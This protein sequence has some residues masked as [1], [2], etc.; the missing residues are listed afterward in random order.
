[1]HWNSLLTKKSLR[2]QLLF[3]VWFVSSLATFV[4]T[5]IQL[6]KDYNQEQDLALS[7]IE[8]IKAN[9]IPSIIKSLWD[10]NSNYLELQLKSLT[11]LPY[12]NMAEVDSDDIQMKHAPFTISEDLVVESIPLTYNQQEIGVLRVG[13]NLLG[14]Q[15]NFLFKAIKIFF[16]QA[17]KTL[18]VT[19]LLLKIFDHLIMKHVVSISRYLK[20]FDLHDGRELKL[21]QADYEVNEF[22]MLADSINKLKSDLS[23]TSKKLT[24]LN[25][26]LEH[27][28]FERTKLLDEERLRSLQ[29]AK[30]A[31]LGEMAG[32]IAHEIN[33]PLA[34]ISSTMQ[35]IRKLHERKKLTDELLLDAVS[36]VEATVV[37]T[38]KIITGLRTVSRTSESFTKEHVMARDVFEDVLG[39]CSE[40]FK[41]NNIKLRIDLANKDFDRILLCDRV[42]LSQVLINLLGNAFDAV[43]GFADP[44]VQIELFEDAQYDFISITDSGNGINPEIAD[45]MF[46]PF[47]TSKEIGKGTGLGLSISKSIMERHGGNILLKQ[48]HQNTCFTLGLPKA[49]I[50]PL[51][52]RPVS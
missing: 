13:M 6:Y 17:L 23:Q 43:Q 16:Y 2:Y 4:F 52:V 44:W 22:T 48:E 21:S 14:I 20:K 46:Y 37:R 51:G 5:S 8:V 34:V 41:N 35:M 3:W 30:L 47:F 29:S 33:N 36:S 12:V 15:K 19:F 25:L 26:D 10:Y 7:Q 49:S 40:K 31:S 9:Y 42:Q 38:S 27:K 28:V 1:M 11:N 50:K 24:E 18:V 32:G 45:K 39:L